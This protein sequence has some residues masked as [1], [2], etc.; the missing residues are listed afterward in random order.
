MTNR[1]RN[2]D[3]ETDRRLI[4]G[5]RRNDSETLAAI[6]DSHAGI[7][8]GLAAR[9]LGI[10]SEA[11]DVVQE[12]FLALWRQAERLD[13][14]RG[15]RSYLLTIVHNKSIDRLRQRSRKNEMP[16]D[17]DAPIPA[18][19]EDPVESAERASDRASVRAALAALPL[20]QRQTVE[21]A[22]FGGLTTGEVAERMQV[23]VGTV[24]S[25]LRLALI[26]LRRILVD[27]V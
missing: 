12:S 13:P 7:A 5:L 22:Y 10:T 8:Y 26:H 6:Y 21:M 20:E 15:I 24:K 27:P 23:P 19:G 16:L 1:Q 4:E 9:I 17:P 11:E 14:S 2:I 3:E 25:R 18:T